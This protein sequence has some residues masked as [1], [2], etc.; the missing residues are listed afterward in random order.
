MSSCSHTVMMTAV[1]NWFTKKLSI[2][3]GVM[4]SGV[5]LSG[6]LIPIIAVLIESVGWRDAMF[7]AGLSTWVIVIPISLLIRYK[8][9]QYGYLLDGEESTIDAIGRGVG[10]SQVS[11]D[12]FRLGKIVA[13]RVF[14]HITLG[15]TCYAFVMS[16]IVTHVMPYLSSIG[17]GLI[18][19]S[20]VASAMPIV[21][22]LGRLGFGWFGDRFKKIRLSAIGF[23]MMSFGLVLF[24]H[25]DSGHAWLIVLFLILY[26]IGWGGNVTLRGALFQEYF[27]RE[28]FGT[29]YGFITGVMM[30][31]NIAGAPMVGLA[32]D[33]W[34]GYQGVWSALA[35]VTLVAAL[36]M[37]TTPRAG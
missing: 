3:M 14:W 36:I 37:A 21:S 23:V 10:P 31:G 25:V 1:S 30:L 29:I 20:L 2:A 7:I 5:A 33:R 26:G 18:A 22:I 35:G 6:L 8:P 11:Q 19:A 17:I 4:A 16:A 32:F 24:D 13:D 34:G 28:R 27:G 12:N 15:F 9:E